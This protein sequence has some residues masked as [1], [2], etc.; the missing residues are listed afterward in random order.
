MLRV[1]LLVPY[2]VD[3]SPGQRFRVEQWLR[4]L[5]DDSVRAD[6][7]P[8]FSPQAFAELYEP[9][10]TVRK[11]GR[12]LS[13]LTRRMHDVVASGKPDVVVL[14]RE[15]FPLGPPV[16]EWL[17]ERRHPVVFDFD[18]AIYLGD[19]S[20]ANRR[21]A[22]LKAPGKTARI[23]AGA[24]VTTVGNEHLSAYASQHSDRVV[25]LPTTLDVEEY[26]P[27]APRAAN[28]PLRIG[29]SGSP[30]TGAHL[31]AITPALRRV[32][33]RVPARLEVI[34][35]P[36]FSIA[37]SDAVTSRAWRRETELDDVRGF[38]IGLMP[39]PDDEWS[40]G[41][42]GFKAL[43]YMALGVP[44]IASPVGVN[45]EIIEHGVNG[46][47]ASTEDEWVE[48]IEQLARDPELCSRL[49]T[50]GRKTVVERYSG[51]RWAPRF[52]EVLEEAAATRP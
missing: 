16:L 47:H 11:V 37:G 18:D 24:A 13:A 41:K 7:R 25:V 28:N 20:S 52:L 34:G 21:V 49:A 4:L 30:T 17:A 26:Q 8:L 31:A 44:A 14:Y 2:P 19:T 1:T 48:A 35:A 50:E 40:R 23:I 38:D 3:R 45:T 43:L 12:T 33:E 36:G 29:W 51:Q 9:G 22:F 32:L 10:L 42:C 15:A 39:L 6:I 46:L 5:P 27:S